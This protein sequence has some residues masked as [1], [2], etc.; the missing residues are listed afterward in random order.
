NGKNTSAWYDF[1]CLHSPLINLVFNREIASAGF[2]LID[3]VAD[4]ANGNEWKWPDA[5][6]TKEPKFI[7]IPIP[8]LMFD[9]C[10]EVMWRDSDVHS[11]S[12]ILGLA[13][14]RTEIDDTGPN[15]AMGLEPVEKH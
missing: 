5:W 13:G 7:E 15:E 1:W 6:T 3:N 12:C 2:R 4:L 8:N 11:L 14:N 10:D 9:K